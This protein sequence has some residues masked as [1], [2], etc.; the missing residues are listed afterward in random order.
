MN[1]STSR[2]LAV[3]RI[4]VPAIAAAAIGLAA[5]PASGM[6]LAGT[7]WDNGTNWDNG[8]KPQISAWNGP[9]WNGPS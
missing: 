8:I 9:S 5:V 4:L 7:S 1:T 6:I 2:W 3:R